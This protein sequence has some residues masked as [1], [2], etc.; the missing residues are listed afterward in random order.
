MNSR[1]NVALLSGDEVIDFKVLY[2]LYRAYPN[3]HIICNDEK[4][5]I[6]YSRYKKS[7]NYIPWAVSGED[8]EE[9][10]TK[11]KEYCDA[12]EIKIIVTGGSKS[13]I[14]LDRYKHIF[15]NQIPFPTADDQ[16]IENTDN[17]W[18]FAKTLMAEGISTPFTMLVDTEE[19]VAD[20]K[21]AELEEKI[22]FPMIV[23]PVH[24]DGG[25]GVRLIHDFEELKDHVLGRHPYND[26]PL[27]VQEYIEG[28]DIDHSFVSVDGTI[29]CYAVQRWENPD[30]LEFC[31]N[32]QVEKLA[33]QIIDVFDYSGP[34]H[35]DMIIDS[36]DGK[37]YVLEM[38]P[39]FWRSVPAAM[40]AGLNIVQSA[41][42]ASLGKEFASEGAR[43]TYV[44][45]G[46]KIKNLIKKPWTYFSLPKTDRQEIWFILTDPMPQLMAFLGKGFGG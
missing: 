3:V 24:G 45:P 42:D 17:K 30:V 6:K 33:E 35:F 20:E 11:I 5:L 1:V 13:S 15:S 26:L 8:Q 36:N 41:V 18:I 37:V 29:L 10:A 21:K 22:G 4:S 38:N 44:L 7:F 27:I 14:Y 9:V 34:G 28:W 46:A 16:T 43:G 2:C 32:E 25:L 39:G 12:E 40:W 31:K 19:A 23:K